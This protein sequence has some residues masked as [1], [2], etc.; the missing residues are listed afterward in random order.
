MSPPPVAEDF[1]LVATSID[2]LAGL[3]FDTAVFCHGTPV[4]SDAPAAFRGIE[5]VT[6]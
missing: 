1:A 3:E 2:K 5:P 4:T 6:V